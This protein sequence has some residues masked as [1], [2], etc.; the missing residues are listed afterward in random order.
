MSL[1]KK[2]FYSKCFVHFTLYFKW[3]I[4]LHFNFLTDDWMSQKVPFPAKAQEVNLRKPC[5]TMKDLTTLDI[6]FRRT[7]YAIITFGLKHVFQLQERGQKI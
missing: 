6:M 5:C 7:V 2:S 1:T 3:A 4:N